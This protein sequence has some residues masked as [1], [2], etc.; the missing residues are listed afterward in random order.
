MT[1]VNEEG[2]GNYGGLSVTQDVKEEW[3]EEVG[4]DVPP[5]RDERVHDSWPD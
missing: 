1:P 4:S 2:G 5:E 3:P